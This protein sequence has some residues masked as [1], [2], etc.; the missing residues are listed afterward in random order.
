MIVEPMAVVKT[1]RIGRGSRI[2]SFAYVSEDVTIGENVVIHPH[3]VIYPGV[4]IGNGVEIFPSAVVGKEPKG[5]GALARPLTFEREVRIGDHCSVGP[6]AVIYCDVHVG[7]RSLIGDGASIREQC[8]LGERT[9]VGRHVTLNYNTIV[10]SRTK[11]MDHAWLAGNMTVGDDVF[12]SGG[13]MTANDNAIGR[14][15]YSE[16]EVRGPTIENGAAIGAAAVLLPR[17]T[18][19]RGAIVAANAVV[20]RDVEEATL[21]VGIPAAYVRHLTGPQGE[22]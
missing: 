3:V 16:D 15:G 1:D 21:V 11:I 12:I 7:P 22:Q 9:V 10:G 19:G 6:H 17:V 13:V 5:V 18:V 2:A 20:T 14:A 8:R 4:H